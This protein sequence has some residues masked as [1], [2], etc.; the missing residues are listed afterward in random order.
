MDVSCSPCRGAAERGAARVPAGCSPAAWLESSHSDHVILPTPRPTR[1]QLVARLRHVT[2]CCLTAHVHAQASH[3]PPIALGSTA[4]T[5]DVVVLGLGY[6]GLPLA[7]EAA[8]TGLKVVG[9]D[10]STAVVDGLNAGRSHVDDLSDDDIREMLE[11]DFRASSDETELASAKT[12]VVC[13]PTP[14]AADGSPDLGAVT[15]AIQTV[16]RQLQPGQVVILESTTW[17]GTTEEIVQP[18]L[19]EGGL[20]AGTDFYLAF[21]P[22]RIDP[23]N[24]TYGIK[25]T[26]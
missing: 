19:E 20:T 1:S 3:E 10:I 8:R 7:H 26:P 22:E 5:T 9:F 15:G 6:V 17:P 16:S 14:L 13:V 4:V 2:V 24:P 12:I 21:S 23:G 18:L 25:N 11:A